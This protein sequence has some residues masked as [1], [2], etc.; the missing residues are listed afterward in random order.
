MKYSCD[1]AY[2]SWVDQFPA[3]FRRIAVL[4]LIILPAKYNELPTN[5]IVDSFYDTSLFSYKYQ[6]VAFGC[7][8]SPEFIW[9]R[10]VHSF[11]AI[12]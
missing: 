5:Y 10:A 3:N 4:G 8:Q 1:S 12:E 11:I 6:V 2:L 9:Y 7:G